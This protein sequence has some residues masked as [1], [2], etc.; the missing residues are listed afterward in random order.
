MAR[1]VAAGSEW[2]L[3]VVLYLRDA[4]VRELLTIEEG[5]EIIEDIFRQ[6]AAGKVENRPTIELAL[7]RGVFRLK[8]GGTYHYNTFG[9]K[10]YPFGGRYTVFVYDLETGLDGVVE[11]RGLTEVR[12]GAVSAVATKYMA[13]PESETMGIIGTGREARAQLA[14]LCLVRPFR[15]IKAYSRSRDNRE[16]FAAEMSKR[17]EIDVIPVDS[18]AEC[19][20][21][22]DVVTT[23]TSARDP[24]LEGAWLSEG[25]HINA[26]GATTPERRELDEEAVERCGTIVVEH[27]PQARAECGEL[28][29][30]AEKGKLNWDDVR[31]MKDIVVG[32]VPGRKDGAEITLLD[33]IGVG[34]EDVALATYVLKKARALSTPI[35]VEMPFEPPYVNTRGR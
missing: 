8:A 18:G 11:A 1:Q 31:E 26:V 14:S 2:R 16:T 35:G 10:A 23:I 29:F 9:F 24:V 20:R 19:V 34:A 28:L 7:P 5:N 4:E 12:T 33:S 6:E 15:R 17:L 3:Q 21:D 13:R 25:T 22:A 30:L 32:T 27:L